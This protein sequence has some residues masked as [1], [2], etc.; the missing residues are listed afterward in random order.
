MSS[1][2]RFDQLGS[3]YLAKPMTQFFGEIVTFRPRGQP[4]RS[5][6]AVVDRQQQAQA[7]ASPVVLIEAPIDDIDGITIEEL[8]RGEDQIDIAI[9]APGGQV[10]TRKIAA[11]R[12]AVGGMITLEVV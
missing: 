11:Y 2:S 3:A 8:D 9:E 5:F 12:D 4:A 6:K 1:S 7:N 10:T